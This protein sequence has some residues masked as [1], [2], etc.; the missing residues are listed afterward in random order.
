[1]SKNAKQKSVVEGMPLINYHEAGID[2][3]DK[4]HV[5][6]V[7]E[8][9]DTESVKTFGTFT[10]DLTD[11]AT[12]LKRCKIETVAM[13]S[14]GV[15]WKPLYTVLIQAGFEVYLVNAKHVKNVTGRKNDEDDARWIQRLHSCALLKSSFLPDSQTES[16]R[17]L[18]RFRNSLTRDSS[19][20]I[21]RIQKSLEL[22]NVKIHTVISDITGKT[23]IA[24]LEAIIGG[25]RE[26][27]QFMEYVDPRIQ[28]SKEDILK[29]LTGNWQ[30]EHLITLK[31]AYEIYKFFQ[32]KIMTIEKEIETIL[33]EIIASKHDGEITVESSPK[34]LQKAKR[35]AKNHP[36]FNV[37]GYLKAI[38]QVDVME[39][40]GLSANGALE[41]LAETGMDLSK[42]ETEDKFIGWLNLCPNNKISGG[43][44]ISSSKFKKKPN[45]ATQAF[46]AAAN[47]LMRSNHWLGDYF[48]KMRAK[49]GQKYAIVATARK[50]ALIYYK[51]VRYKMPFNPPD[52]EHY[53]QKVR[54]A[55]IAY[56]ERAL[57]KLKL[58]AA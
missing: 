7:P 54:S 44:L 26:P 52:L 21:L 18:T 42:W 49:G 40:Y 43:K 47:S 53:R 31:E 34:H 24:M 33:L 36:L 20:Y 2:V 57:E 19:T 50:I 39:I 29:S 11:I 45:G 35:K 30:K 23:G 1:M 22:M 10:C 55:K 15:Y 8:G 13:E 5:V 25:Q 16:L 56:L 14:T 41:I 27:E 38:H 12:W 32:V 3:G 6:A 46:R 4:L 48:R 9:R 51:I 58:H 28:A 17:T 37:Q